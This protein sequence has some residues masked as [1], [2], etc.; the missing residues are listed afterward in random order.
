MMIIQIFDDGINGDYVAGDYIYNVTIPAQPGDSTVEFSFKAKDTIGQEAI[1]QT[2]S[3]FI[4]AEPFPEFRAIWI[5][6]WISGLLNETET[7]ELVDTCRESNLNTLLP[8]VRKS[9]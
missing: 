5:Q 2:Q 1:S 8:E 3:Y 4:H 6:S 7:D 9:W